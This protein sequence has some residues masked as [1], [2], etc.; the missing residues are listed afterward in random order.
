RPIPIREPVSEEMVMETYDRIRNDIANLLKAEL[1]ALE[2][3]EN[4]EK[5]MGPPKAKPKD[6][7]RQRQEAKREGERQRQKLRHGL[8][9]DRSAQQQA[10]DEDEQEAAISL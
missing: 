7:K 2:T 5:L 3:G 10:A 1:A 6:S 4:E 9:P 8:L